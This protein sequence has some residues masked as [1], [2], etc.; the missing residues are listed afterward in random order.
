MATPQLQL[1]ITANVQGQQQV[2]QLQQALQQL[3]NSGA[4]LNIGNPAAGLASG[5]NAATASFGALAAS[6]AAA[7]AAVAGLSMAFKKGL[8]VNSQTE[9][10][11]LGLKGLI[12]TMYEVRDST[13]KIAEGPRALELSAG[14]AEA[15][16]KK[17]RI[18]GMETSATFD[19]LLT[20]FQGAIGAGASAGLGLDTVRE[21]T[22]SIVQAAGALTV[23]MDMINQEVKSLLSG[24]IGADSS[25][26]QA[27][28][29]KNE[30]MK[31]WKEA[32]TIAEELNKRLKYFNLLGPETSKTWTST[33]SAVGDAFNLFLGE[34]SKGAFDDIKTSIQD[35][36][37][38]V[39]D[40]QAGGVS[41]KFK[42]IQEALGTVFDG[43]GTV[44]TDAM[45][46]GVA[47][48]QELSGWFSQHRE[49]V[50]EVATA[51]GQ[52]WEN[53]KG[54]VGVI[55][56][57]IGGVV[58]LVVESGLFSGTLQGIALLVAMVKD[59]FS[60]MK[61]TIAEVGATIIDKIGGPLRTVIGSLRGFV[62]QI[63]VFGASLA[64]AVDGMVRAIPTSGDGL[65]KTAAGIRADFEAGRTAV[66]ATQKALLDNGKT[67]RMQE[68]ARKKAE[69][70]KK[71]ASA[72]G[73]AKAKKTDDDDDKKKKAAKEAE[74]LQKA[75]EAMA[76]AQLEVDKKIN[77]AKRSL[78]QAELDSMLAD[79]KIG[80]EAYLKERAKLQAEEL[81]QERKALRDQLAVVQE[82]A[83]KTKAEEVK[84]QADIKKIQG[85]LDTLEIK[86][87]EVKIKVTAELEAFRREVAVL[88]AELKAKLA[89][90]QGDST[91]AAKLRLEAEQK[92]FRE[93]KTY[94]G[95]SDEGKAT[96]NKIYDANKGKIEFDRLQKD[97]DTRNA[98]LSLKDQELQRQVDAGTITDLQRE[99]KLQ[100][101]RAASIASIELEVQALE[102][103]AKASGNKEFALQAAQAREQLEQLKA[104]GDSV[105][106]S[107]NMAFAEGVTAGITGLLDRSIKSFG[108]FCRGILMMVIQTWQKIAA[109]NLTQK[110]FGAMGGSG[111]TLGGMF[112]A[113]A[114]G[115]DFSKM[116]S[117]FGGFFADG[118]VVRGPGTGT[119][120]SIV[121]MLSNGEGILN[122]DA[123]K[124]LGADWLHWINKWARGYA[125]GG[126]IGGK[127]SG[128][129]S[130]A[131]MGTR[132]GSQVQQ[133]LRIRLVNAID[134][135][136]VQDYMDSAEGEQVIENIM[137]RNSSR[138]RMAL[139]V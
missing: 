72:G 71:K 73:T 82:R 30:D 12:A 35:S 66:A 56:E 25:V 100:D 85:D 28:Q 75:E 53:F 51:A 88:E 76:K 90:A 59:G 105:A 42:G 84:K 21:L 45:E 128:A 29:I 23:P 124:L 109:Q 103:L 50:Y 127:Q 9:G 119:S 79:Q 114:G 64:K 39:F 46:G 134:P 36:M 137:S 54:V 106:K 94:S 44:L 49:T 116:F 125:T 93:S 2:Q 60:L 15:Q 61:M 40:I 110:I 41:D 69:N 24:N 104:Q 58:K 1:R 115:F 108:D 34:A 67:A 83:A 14:L 43:M 70:D 121:A 11:T 138:F 139:G 118:G 131:G 107:I 26:A 102:V 5:A 33:M 20:A 95:L 47:L 77:A 18:A 91:T 57:A 81:E 52:I 126:V 92:A 130:I 32:G 133:A 27:L 113:S 112:S 87:R 13:G 132:L 98:Y 22:V 3:A 99:A 7:A 55:F 123:M 96:A 6:I 111:S 65:R 136:I 63:P 38:D 16:V 4:T 97:I 78:R 48:A 10:A 80:Y 19:Q 68:A 135:G 62:S 120:D 89:E 31:K 74:A 101:A 17:L 122:V 8:D 117:Y 86:E 129:A 37:K